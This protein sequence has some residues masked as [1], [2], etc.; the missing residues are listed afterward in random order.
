MKRERR[1]FRSA[2]ESQ[3]RQLSLARALP[4]LSHPAK[5]RSSSASRAWLLIASRC[6]HAQRRRACHPWTAQLLARPCRRRRVRRV[7]MSQHA[8]RSP[9]SSV[10]RVTGNDIDRCSP[11]QGQSNQ[12]AG[13]SGTL[14]SP[15]LALVGMTWLSQQS[16]SP[17]SCKRPRD[18][19]LSQ[20]SSARTHTRRTP[21]RGL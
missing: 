5:D 9:G 17:P 21:R 3:P 4:P 19:C 16:A 7:F 10:P 1:R 14:I 2:K 11:S 13:P 12:R 20:R 15:V 6:S 8:A 18:A